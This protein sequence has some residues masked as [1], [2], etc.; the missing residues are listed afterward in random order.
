[1]A[2][3][4]KNFDI[5]F[6]TQ[7]T[8]QA[9]TKTDQLSGSFNGLAETAKAAASAF[10]AYQAAAKSIE[11]AKTAAQ[12]ETVRRSFQNLAEEPD[13]MLQSMKKAAAG[14]ISEMELMQKF[15]EA[16]LLGL[17]LERFDEMMEIARGAAQAT[18]QS[19]DF[20]LA[21]ITT[22]L[23]RQSKL[24]L[25]NLGILVSVEDAN[26]KYAESLGKTVSQLT[27]Q[28][29][30]I[31]FVN[32]ALDAGGANLERLGGVATTN[33]EKFDQMT[34]AFEDLKVK[35]GQ[36]LMPIVLAGVD[37]LTDFANSFD[38][39]R[40]QDY[41]IGITTAATALGVYTTAQTGANVAALAFQKALPVIVLTT[42]ATGIAEVSKKLRGFKEE[43]ETLSGWAGKTFQ[44]DEMAN[45]RDQ[46]NKLDLEGLQKL[47]ES[48][49][50]A[51]DGTSAFTVLTIEQGKQIEII[52]ARMQQLIEN[53]KAQSE[54]EEFANSQTQ[55]ALE[56]RGIEGNLLEYI[57]GEYLQ[58]VETQKKL[59]RQKEKEQAF[60][61]RLIEQYP[62]LAA[63]LGLVN[64]TVEQQATAFEQAEAVVRTMNNSVMML[65]QAGIKTGKIGKRIAQTQALVDTYASANAAYKAALALPPPGG[66]ILA[67]IAAAAAVA[68]GLENV[69]QIEKAQFGMD[70]MVSEP[71]LILAGEA[72]P[73]RVDITPATQAGVSTGGGVT[74]NFN[75]PVTSSQFVRDTIIPE[76]KRATS[77]GLA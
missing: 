33:A 59:V 74:I 45:F 27:D 23:G 69:K 34:A 64:T 18:G 55:T 12:T 10:V 50:L 38:P 54:V 19:M 66:L 36:E 60:N 39:K 3:G 67:P 53:K 2:Q 24:M 77:S 70:R 6:R 4:R 73:E 17:P 7:G 28:E 26:K 22:G 31:A 65:G 51:G 61:A 21:S 1:M 43:A 58:F 44:I 56:L 25:D 76:I 9:K 41:A 5:I 48:L 68:A 29:R 30:K 75:G 15:N 52:N 11:F 71:T 47:T 57:D 63:Q 37:G 40:L 72:G 13:K 46:V 35:I 62:E 14:T 42:I 20:M 16:S 49:G 32:A 8:A